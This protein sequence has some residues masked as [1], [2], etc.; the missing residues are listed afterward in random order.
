M[1]QYVK[2]EYQQFLP[3]LISRD[4][5]FRGI[6]AISAF[7]SFRI[8]ILKKIISNFLNSLNFRKGNQ[9]FLSFLNLRN[10]IS[11]WNVGSFC[12]TQI[13]Q[14]RLQKGMSANSVFPT[15]QTSNPMGERG[16]FL[17]LLN[18]RTSNHFVWVIKQ[19]T[20]PPHKRTR[21]PMKMMPTRS[22]FSK[23]LL[24]CACFHPI[25][26][27]TGV[28]RRGPGLQN[29]LHG[30]RPHPGGWHRAAPLR[31]PQPLRVVPDQ[32][33]PGVSHP[34]FFGLFSVFHLFLPKTP[35]KWAL[36]IT[37]CPP[38]RCGGSR[39]SGAS[40][41]RAPP[42]PPVGSGQDIGWGTT[43]LRGTRWQNPSL[44]SQWSAINPRFL[45][46]NHIISTYKI[47]LFEQWW[48]IPSG[49]L[50]LPLSLRKV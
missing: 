38:V 36:R 11:E 34:F 18:F 49:S 50:S 5:I 25:S 13:P 41:S 19:A 12:L 44:V 24:K 48:P 20:T 7:L 26:H 17:P 37:C 8:S 43:R 4:P 3:S 30:G 40:S 33:H 28:A 32:T 45:P 46:Q 22:N 14:I 15:F 2:N 39:R 9:H 21:T 16:R 23:F 47:P 42:T 29:P 10:P 6:V 27:R 1:T 31:C 35:F